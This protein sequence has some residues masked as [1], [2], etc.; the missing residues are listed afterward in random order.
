MALSAANT[1]FNIG[2]CTLPHVHV[3]VCVKSGC[4][5]YELDAKPD[6]RGQK[7]AQSS[8]ASPPHKIMRAAS[9]PHLGWEIWVC[10]LVQGSKGGVARPSHQGIDALVQEVQGEAWPQL[11]PV[12]P[13]LQRPLQ[14]GCLQCMGD[15]AQGGV[16]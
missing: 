9:T 2:V 8:A 7:Q 15:A 16:R 13:H 3:C 10:R 6:K 1:S 4:I 5:A 12:R 14:L 11:R